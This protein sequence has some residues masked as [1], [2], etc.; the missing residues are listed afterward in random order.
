[1]KKQLVRAVALAV[2]ALTLAVAPGCGVSILSRRPA[3]ERV[4]VQRAPRHAAYVA[5]APVVAQPVYVVE[6]GHH[7][8]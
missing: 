4:Y 5:P 2:G 6:R 3:H 8:Y 1:M 7:H